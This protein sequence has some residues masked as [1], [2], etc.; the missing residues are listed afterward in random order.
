MPPAVHPPP[1]RIDP[2]SLERDCHLEVFTAGG[3]G[4]QHRNKTQN[5]VRIH[6]LPSGLV[7]TATE[8]RSLEANRRTALER[9]IVRLERLNAVKRPRKPTRPTRGSVEQ[10]LSEKAHTARRKTERRQRDD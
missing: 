10:R 7:V 2:R 3:P 5:A 9:L 1:Y 6:H 8:R 4:G